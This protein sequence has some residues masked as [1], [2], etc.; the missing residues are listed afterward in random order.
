M[1]FASF[2]F[3]FSVSWNI[4]CPPP[5][6]SWSVSSVDLVSHTSW[7]ISIKSFW[8]LEL[9]LPRVSVCILYF[10]IVTVSFVCVCVFFLLTSHNQSRIFIAPL[11]TSIKLLEQWSLW[12]I[13]PLHKIDVYCYILKYNITTEENE[14]SIW[15]QLP[16]GRLFMCAKCWLLGHVTSI[17]IVHISSSSPPPLLYWLK[18]VQ[19]QAGCVIYI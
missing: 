5:L 10:C 16:F 6:I 4:C 9:F 17:R 18:G 13:Y 19:H 15:W 2:W 1:D 14:M 8:C 3:I 7:S 12:A 11:L